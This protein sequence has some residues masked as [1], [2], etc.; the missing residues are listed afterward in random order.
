MEIIIA[1][2]GLINGP[3]NINE[4]K[5]D[6]ISKNFSAFPRIINEID[7]WINDQIFLGH[8]KPSYKVNLEFIKKNSSKLILH[9]KYINNNSIKALNNLEEILNSCHTFS[10]E[11]DDFTITSKNW[12]WS[13]PRR[14]IE[15]NCIVV[16]P[17]KFL[18]FNSDEDLILLKKA[19]GICTDYPLKMVGLI[20]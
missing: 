15:E 10:H 5:P 3:C 8:D 20:G 7:I 11:E 4:N 17:E 2:R 16:M 14:G 6:H 18:N 13:H 19:K 9:I 12:I 1:H